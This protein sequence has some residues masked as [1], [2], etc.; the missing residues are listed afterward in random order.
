MMQ[1]LNYI[2]CG[3]YYIPDIR[4]TEENRLIGRWDLCT[5][6]TSR[7]INA[8]ARQTIRKFRVSKTKAHMVIVK[9]MTIKNEQNKNVKNKRTVVRF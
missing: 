9:K 2:R 6:I 5:E 4:L 1:E 8:T 3:D 7:S